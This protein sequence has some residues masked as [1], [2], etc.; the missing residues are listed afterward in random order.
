ML[1]YGK[2]GCFVMQ[3]LYV[4][5]LCASC[6]S[7]QCCILHEFVKLMLVRICMNIKTVH[8]FVFKVFYTYSCGLRNFDNLLDIF[9]NHI[10]F[11]SPMIGN[12]SSVKFGSSVLWLDLHPGT[13][14]EYPIVMYYRYL[15]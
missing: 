11:S 7:S 13:Q 12:L 5:V 2:Y 6:G 9:C 8:I 4:R 3:M 14:H 15:L 1:V 10:C